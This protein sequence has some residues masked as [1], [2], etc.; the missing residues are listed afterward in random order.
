MNLF[1]FAGYWVYLLV[2][3]NFYMLA[4]D[5]KNTQLLNKM[6]KVSTRAGDI[7]EQCGCGSGKSIANGA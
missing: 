4:V 2:S 6:I 7:I 3:D 1:K 5:A